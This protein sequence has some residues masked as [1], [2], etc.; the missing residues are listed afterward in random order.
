MAAED[1]YA[2]L[3]QK[4]WQKVIDLCNQHPEGPFLKLSRGRDSVLQKALYA[5]DVELVL[6]LL[7]NAKNRFS[8]R[9]DFEDRLTNDVNIINNT[10]LHVAATQDSCLEAAVK[11]YEFSGHLLFARNNRGE[12]P[13][14]SATRY[15]QFNMFKFLNK[16]IM[17][18]VSDEERRLQ[19]FYKVS[20]E[21][22]FYTILHVAIYNEHFG[23]SFQLLLTNESC[24][25]NISS[26]CNASFLKYSSKAIMH[27][28]HK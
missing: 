14:F 9:K 5:G 26:N 19:L 7:D 28:L 20:K 3:T 16:K 17:D 12:F 8:E 15:G 1:M 10:I 21:H 11:I 23:M 2:A 4:D 25:F 27:N 6:A 18:V 13:I 22:E 24:M